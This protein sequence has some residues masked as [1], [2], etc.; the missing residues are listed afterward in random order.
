MSSTPKAQI[1]SAQEKVV[2][3]LQKRLK[4]ETTGRLDSNAAKDIRDLSVALGVAL[5][6]YQALLPHAR[7]VTWGYTTSTAR[8]GVKEVQ[9]HSNQRPSDATSGPTTQS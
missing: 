2:R 8:E 4:E 3:A 9:C 1:L 6:K 7:P 5:D